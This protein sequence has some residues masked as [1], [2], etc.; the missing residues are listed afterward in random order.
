MAEYR[1]SD[2]HSALPFH[3]TTIYLKK[4][5][6]EDDDHCSSLIGGG[7]WALPTDVIKRELFEAP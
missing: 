1:R 3:F 5:R 6:L 2:G 4:M 7:L